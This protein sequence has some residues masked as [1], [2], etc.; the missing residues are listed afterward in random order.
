MAL[1]YLPPHIA[2]SFACPWDV[3]AMRVWSAESEDTEPTLA[4]LCE[5]RIVGST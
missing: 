5:L 2:V 1:P 4:L 3:A